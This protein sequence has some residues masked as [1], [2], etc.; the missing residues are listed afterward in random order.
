M[1][2]CSSKWLKQ[3]II[4]ILFAFSALEL[5]CYEI[6]LW[7]RTRLENVSF[8]KHLLG[9]LRTSLRHRLILLIS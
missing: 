3:E 7:L 2:F 9:F 4:N 6:Q 1:Y 8:W 5:K